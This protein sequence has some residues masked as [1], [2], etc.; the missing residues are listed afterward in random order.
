MD[1]ET[2]RKYFPA[3]EEVS[4]EELA[5]RKETDSY[6]AQLRAEGRETPVMVERMNEP[7]GLDKNFRPYSS[8]DNTKLSS[9]H[10]EEQQ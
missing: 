5:R 6:I 8:R 1:Y 7:L 2:L 10:E 4:P 9:R 3:G